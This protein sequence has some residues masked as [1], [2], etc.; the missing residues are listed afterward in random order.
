MEE[1]RYPEEQ[2]R[3]GDQRPRT[4]PRYREDRPVPPDD[5][6]FESREQNIRPPRDDY[7]RDRKT[8]PDNR[9][10]SPAQRRGP[11]S[12]TSRS[13]VTRNASYDRPPSP[14]YSAQTDLRYPPPSTTS[15]YEEKTPPREGYRDEYDRDRIP[16]RIPPVEDRGRPP[17]DDRVSRNAPPPATVDNKGYANEPRRSDYDYDQNRTADRRSYEREQS[18]QLGSDRDSDRRYGSDTNRRTSFDRESG[19]GRST[20]DRSSSDREFDHKRTTVDYPNGGPSPPIAKLRREGQMER[21]IPAQNLPTRDQRYYDEE[22]RSPSPRQQ[23][24]TRRG[25]DYD[26]GEDYYERS[27]RPIQNESPQYPPSER[28]RL[29]QVEES[30]RVSPHTSSK[31]PSR[32]SQGSSRTR[33]D[34][35]GRGES[36]SSDASEALAKSPNSPYSSSK[37]YKHSVNR[38]TRNYRKQRSFSSSDEELPSTSECQSCED[39]D[40][41]NVSESGESFLLCTVQY[42]NLLFTVVYST[43]CYLCAPSNEN[44]EPVRKNNQRN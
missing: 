44:F 18:S 24:P 12:D 10:V 13:S 42:I 39:V 38:H 43:L 31:E 27:K 8:I 37:H 17:V 26:R 23:A 33:L 2:Y 15:Y 20:Y 34:A 19:G 28:R 3:G 22:R 6:G 30:Y 29:P 1:R 35:T 36:L 4:E 16:G 25:D 9:P 41:E 32:R 11:G 21:N 14:R 5:R 7:D 40:G